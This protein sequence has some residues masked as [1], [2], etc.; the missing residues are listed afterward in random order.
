MLKVQL[1]EIIK[2]YKSKYKTFLVD[3]IMAAKGHT[4]LR[5]PPYHPD[6]NPIE[7]IWVDVKQW[8]GANNKTSRTNN[9]KHLCEQRFKETGEDKWISVCEHADELEKQYCEQEGIT[10][11]RMLRR[12]NSVAMFLSHVSPAS[13]LDGSGR[14]IRIE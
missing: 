14:L 1:N 12:Q 10:E 3:E 13:L 5:L 11:E 6:F 9:V 2:A 8:V 7:L 4:V